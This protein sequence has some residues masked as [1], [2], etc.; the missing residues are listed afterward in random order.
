MET[1]I[2][3]APCKKININYNDYIKQVTLCTGGDLMEFSVFLTSVA[4]VKTFVNAASFYPYEVDV[5]SGR[6][7]INGKSIMGLFSID[8]FQIGVLIEP[9]LIEITLISL[10]FIS[11]ERE[12]NKISKALLDAQYGAI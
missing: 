6:Y 7:V 11:I 8:L 3:C 4:D 2:S 12:L 10:F 9:G 5:L 1:F